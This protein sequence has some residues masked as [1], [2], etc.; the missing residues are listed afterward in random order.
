VTRW[1]EGLPFDV[2]SELAHPHLGDRLAGVDG[3]DLASFAGPH[4]A[5]GLGVDAW[6]GCRCRSAAGAG[7]GAGGTPRGQ[8][9]LDDVIAMMIAERRAN[10][11]EDMLTK[12]VKIADAEARSPPDEQ[13]RGHVQGLVQRRPAV[14]RC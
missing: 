11:R 4:G 1:V 13:V 7:T 5:L 14:H 3:T 6:A 8:A 12:A 2:Y 9:K 10:P